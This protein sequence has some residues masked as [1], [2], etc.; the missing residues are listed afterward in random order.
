MD[1]NLGQVDEKIT[2]QGTFCKWLVPDEIK[3]IKNN[4]K[5]YAIKKL[6]LLS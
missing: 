1:G 6:V 5:M 4:F 2:T 3:T